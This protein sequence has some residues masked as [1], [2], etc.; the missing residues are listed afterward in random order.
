MSLTVR[1]ANEPT[2]GYE[3]ESY[4]DLERRT[5]AKF[6]L[7]TELDDLT[8]EGMSEGDA[9]EIVDVAERIIKILRKVRKTGHPYV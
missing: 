9:K 7:T 3:P 8:E 4:E 5:W 6:D 2:L 1:F